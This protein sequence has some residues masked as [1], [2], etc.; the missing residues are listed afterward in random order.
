MTDDERT[1]VKTYVPRS[2]KEAWV[3]HADALDMSQSEFL[4]TMVQAGRRGFDPVDEE[5]GSP[6]ATPGG[7]ALEERVLSTLSAAGVLD[8]GE[9]VDRLAGDIERDVDDALEALQDARAVRYSG[10]HGGYVVTG[11]DSR[12]EST[13]RADGDVTRESSDGRGSR[14][15]P[16]SEGRRESRRPAP[17]SDRERPAS[18][19]D[20]SSSER[21]SDPERSPPEYGERGGTD[22]RRRDAPT[23]PP[24]R[25]RG[26]DE[27]PRRAEGSSRGDRGPDR[28]PAREPERERPTDRQ[29]PRDRQPRRADEDRPPIDSLREARESLDRDGDR[30]DRE[31]A[32]EDDRD[33]DRRSVNDERRYDEY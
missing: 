21:R 19:R 7:Q 18:R 8:W 27:P 23:R 6:D 14:E 22:G 2:Q 10:R 20:R 17:S 33:G 31:R 16:R 26:Y 3:E 1:V 4:R 30:T 11:D 24:E 12:A 29:P 5:A 9:L 15:P 28:R 13:D 32:T 25:A